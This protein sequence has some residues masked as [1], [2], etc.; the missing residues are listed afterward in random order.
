[1]TALTET[2]EATSDLSESIRIANESERKRSIQA[3][4]MLRLNRSL[5]A[6]MTAAN[7]SRELHRQ[8]FLKEERERRY[9]ISQSKATEIL[10]Q[11]D[12]KKAF[13]QD[14]KFA[15]AKWIRKGDRAEE[16]VEQPNDLRG[17]WIQRHLTEALGE[18][19]R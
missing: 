8:E 2:A 13:L 7:E 14:D 12:A 6:Q 5:I 19:R 1:M 3:E 18:D 16:F 15:M 9:A 17:M 4:E 10:P 11:L